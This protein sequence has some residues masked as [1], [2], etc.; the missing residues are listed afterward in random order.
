MEM[1]RYLG[2]RAMAALLLASIAAGP[3]LAQKDGRHPQGLSL[4]QSGK[5]VDP[6]VGDLFHRRADDGSLQQPRH[7][8]AGRA[9]EQ[10]QSIV[11]D[12][13]TSWSWSEDGMHLTFA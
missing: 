8:Q 9:E 11:P 10:L 6:R 2:V 3:A 1:T 5:H 4:G 13:A 7:V 12:L